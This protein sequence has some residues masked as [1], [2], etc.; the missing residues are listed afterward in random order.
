MLESG[1]PGAAA[2][3]G[4]ALQC[5]KDLKSFN[6][7]PTKFNPV[8]FTLTTHLKEVTTITAIDDCGGRHLQNQVK[9]VSL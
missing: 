2:E 9:N 4:E 5:K 8:C 7:C 3:R 6:I 1:L